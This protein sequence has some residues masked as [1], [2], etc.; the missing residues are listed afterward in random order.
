V[1]S[2]SNGTDMVTALPCVT[3]VHDVVA[4]AF[5][6]ADPRARKREQRQ[7]LRTAER[8]RTIVADSTFIADEIGRYLTFP[9]E[10]IVPV[11]LGV[12]APFAAVGERHVLPDGRPYVLHV[13]AHDDRKN[14]GTLIAAWEDAFPGGDVAL[15]F[16]RTSAGLP[17]G[18]IVADAPGDATLAAFYRGAAA[19]AVPSLDEGFGLPLLEALACGAP[20]VASRVAALPEVGG[21]ACAWVDDPLDVDEWA[22]ALVQLVRD[23]ASAQTIAARGPARA[24][25]FTW[26]RC[27]RETAAI[28]HAA[29]GATSA[30]PGAFTSA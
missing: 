21:D 12:S 20:A 5:P 29:A 13:G 26:E 19:V 1:W 23:P 9:R 11:P 16:T 15:V 10:R 30:G 7:L 17:A 3:T 27:A 2:P 28:L 6:A 4:F 18:T 14:V 25:Q 22:A 8:A 24:A